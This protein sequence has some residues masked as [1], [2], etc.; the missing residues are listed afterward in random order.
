MSANLLTSLPQ[1]LR[2]GFR[3]LAK[4]PGFS[5]IAILTLALGIGANTAI[6]SVV[7]GV[8]LN[9]LP[10]H[11]PN[12]LVSMFQE[13][14]NFKNGSISYPNFL[15]WQRMNTT[16][17]GMA[18]YRSAGFNLS[19]NGEPE[20]LHGEMISAGFFEILGVGPILGRTFSADED[21]LGA[22]PT[23]MI[24]EGLWK[25]KFGGRKD[26]IG[27]R[28]V[29][30]D[31]GRT[32]IGVVPSSFHLHIQNFQRGGPMNEVYVPVGEYNEPKFYGERGAGWGLDAIGRLKPGVTL[33][34]AREDMDRI[35]R[36]LTA[37]YPDVNSGKKANVLSL[38]DEMIGDMGPILLILLGAVAFV[39]LIA[40]VNVANLLL[41]RSTARQN[42]FAIRIALGAG[43]HRV[44]RQLLTESLLLSL[45]GGSLGLLI[46]KFGTTAA[47]AAVPRT[48]PRSDDIGLDPR[49]LLF[50]LALSVLAGI[51]FGL[52]P[53]WKASQGSVS[54]Q[55][56]ESGRALAGV[57]GSTQS[58]FVIGEMA[59]AL[60]L[61][62]GAGLMIRTLV[63]LW[64]ADPG[65][66]PKNILTL[67]LSGPASYKAA[68]ADSIR[69]AYRQL[70]DKLAS[71]PGVEAVSFSWGAHPMG[72]D[73]EDFFW[74]VGRPKP[75]KPG[76]YP[77]T[78][79]YDVEPDY[80]KVMQIP[81]K[82]GRFFTAADNEHSAPVVVIDESL[83]KEYFPDQD[84]IGQYLDFNINPSEDKLPNPQ[85]IGI[86][87][88]VNQW[89]L[90]SD[91]PGS[92]HA[93]VYLPM[94]QIPD[95]ELQ[96]G[97]FGGDI[98]LRR[99]QAGTPTL[100]T[101]RSRMLE[102]NSEL[103]IHN[104]QDMEKSVAES[105]SNK[106]FTMT[107]LG[108]FALLALLLASIGIYGVLSYMVG[109]RSKEIGVRMALGAQKL[110]VLRM[111]LKDGAQMTMAG[112]IVGLVGAFALTRLMRTML[113]GVRPTDPLTFTAVAALL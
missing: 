50:T 46:A 68:S 16:F 56:I 83:A 54:R 64:G 74:F 5:L 28:M 27:Q 25:R 8:L 52:I 33:Q 35:S 23:A 12:Q 4:S 20:R 37:A 84:P 60:V 13:I 38:K 6:F 107:L 47:L 18:A 110:D 9:P 7:N 59:M 106:R 53:A 48:L 78:I 98:F 85:I 87:G 65:F 99:Q 86:V 55:L 100:A 66:N 109:Q 42:E 26:I 69:S 92:L 97:G 45:V 51:I 10:F 91:G 57:R 93:E 73:S 24:T 39:L 22:N 89:G 3:V 80:L 11:D 113:Y 36:A 90:D 111:V 105:I 19:G 77:M 81:V 2:Y 29:L 30:D 76:D 75:S 88:H 103:V 62:I 82:R 44:I 79:E 70:H 72:S 34:Q 63:Q 112:I 67:E 61:L 40:C 49:V 94:A 96:R 32:I 1:D 108:I 14:P 43:Q 17:A 41:A 95:K 71:T 21:R 104:P 101:L 102:Y 58:V 31:A 15:D